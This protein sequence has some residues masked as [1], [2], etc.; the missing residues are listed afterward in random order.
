MTDSAKL[1]SIELFTGAGGLALGVCR[2]GFEHLALVELNKDAVASLNVNR[3]RV[4]EMAG[5]PADLK[6]QDAKGVSFEQFRGKV[7]LIAGGSPCQPFSLGGKH[8]GDEDSRNLFPV[9]FRAVREARP[10][11]VIVEN[12]R[13]LM[14]RSFSEYFNYIE[15]QLQYPCET[16][17]PD[18]DWRAH[19]QRLEQIAKR[20][21]Y[22]GLRYV[23]G[24]Q[25]LNAADYGLPQKRER[26]FIVGFR[27]D[28]G[29]G[30][31]KLEPTHS[32]DA[33]LYEMYVTGS[34]WKEHGLR[35]RPIPAG[36]QGRIDALKKNGRSM[37]KTER[38]RTVRDA[39]KGLPSPLVR[40]DHPTVLNHVSNP[41]ARRYPGHTGSPLDLPAKTLKAGVHGV[42]GGE[43][44]LVA[45]DDSVRYFTVREAARLQGFPD[46]Y[47]F[48][49]AWGEAFRQ[50]GN[51]VPVRLA[52]VVAARVR[53][54]LEQVTRRDDEEALATSA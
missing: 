2:A 28:L 37:L 23:V 18:E 44:M 53:E 33:L 25:L 32:E 8:K 11:A 35:A 20:G 38:W 4:P 51:A 7:N 36:L 24:H 22:V 30:W 10:D 17:Q 26:V 46:E 9:V 6:P 50:L 45:D 21:H 19:K 41:G 54:M 48:T 27:S 42:P 43:N 29:I 49:G 34:Y 14:R 1:T 15:L 52:E 31:S 39:L 12:V 16:P 3:Q 13:G 40:T 47:F 5:F